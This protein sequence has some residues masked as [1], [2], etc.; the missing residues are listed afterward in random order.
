MIY[1]ADSLTSLEAKM[2]LTTYMLNGESSSRCLDARQVGGI[3][4][5]P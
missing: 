1:I 4:E 5:Q 2:L 3:M